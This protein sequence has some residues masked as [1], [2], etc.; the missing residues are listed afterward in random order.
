MSSGSFWSNACNYATGKPLQTLLDAVYAS[1]SLTVTRS[2]AAVCA[3]EIFDCMICCRVF[4]R[5]TAATQI[6]LFCVSAVAGGVMFYRWRRIGEE[7]RGRVWRL[8]GWFSG[9]MACGSCVGAVAWAARMMNLVNLFKGN[10]SNPKLEVPSLL[11]V[12]FSWFSAFHVTYAIEFLC[13]CAAQLM[14][15]DRLFVFAAPEGTG[16]R[17][18]WAAAGRVVMAA[19]LLGNAVGLAGNVASAVHYQ[20]ASDAASASSA[21]YASNITDKGDEFRRLRIKQVQLGG[22]TLSVQR[23]SEVAVLLLIIVAF[24]VVGVLSARRVSASL[25]VVDAASAAAASGRALRRRMLG[26]TAFIFVTFLLRSVLST[27]TAVSYELRDLYKACPGGTCDA[28]CHNVYTHVV[29]W[30]VYTPAFESTIVL[31]SSPVALLVALWGMTPKATLHVMKSS[32]QDGEISLRP[33]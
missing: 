4:I 13:M 1:C 23:F 18:Q 19:V 3:A 32:R 8:Y 12:A 24:V 11:A 9:L 21:Y 30:M 7:D 28:S 22:S 10:F 25:L 15:L 17:R 16:T 20:K 14:V 6:A 33:M 2:P 5:V 31:I 29:G 26:T 27:M